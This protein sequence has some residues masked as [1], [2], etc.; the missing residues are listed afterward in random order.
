MAFKSKDGKRNFGNRQQAQAYDERGSQKESHQEAMPHEEDADGGVENEGQ[1]QSPMDIQEHV[2]QHGPAEKVEIHHSEGKHTKV[3]HHGGAK[4]VSHHDSA[5]E[6]HQHGMMAAG[7][8][9]KDGHEEPDG[10]EGQP[11]MAGGGA[12]PGM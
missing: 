4:H 7:V 6:A 9:G 8:E 5:E 1:E 12:I 3:S 11:A 10:D 2:A